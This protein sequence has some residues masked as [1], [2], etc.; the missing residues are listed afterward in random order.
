MHGSIVVAAAAV[1]VI[2]LCLHLPAQNLMLEYR[3]SEGKR[4]DYLLLMNADRD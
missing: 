3:G 1:I 4:Q 2:D